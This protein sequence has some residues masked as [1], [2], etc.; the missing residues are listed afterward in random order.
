MSI[1]ISGNREGVL[2]ALQSLDAKKWTD[3]T[4][5]IEAIKNTNWNEYRVAIKEIKKRWWFWGKSY[6]EIWI[7]TGT[8]TIRVFYSKREF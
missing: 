5:G 7:T 4:A 6:Q 1:T 3:I 2:V 8:N